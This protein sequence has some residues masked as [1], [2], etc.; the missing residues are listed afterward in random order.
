MVWFFQV[1]VAFGA[2]FVCIP[3]ALFGLVLLGV[4]VQPSATPPDRGWFLLTDL[5]AVFGVLGFASLLALPVAPLACALAWVFIRRGW[6]GWLRLVAGTMVVAA[7]ASVMVPLLLTHGHS[8]RPLDWAGVKKLA[9]MGLPVGLFYG[10]VAR[11]TLKFFMPELY[12]TNPGG[13]QSAAAQPD[14]AKH[15]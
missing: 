14:L 15:G 7:C 8:Q 10:V 3:M 13:V 6:H 12:E 4:T 9:G 11:L 1:A 2:T 5:V